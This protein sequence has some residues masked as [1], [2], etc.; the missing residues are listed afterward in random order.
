M[1]NLLT[2][3]RI[4][5]AVL[6]LIFP[7]FS[8]WYYVFY[9]LGG[10]TDAADGA[11]ARI[12]GTATDFGNKFDTAADIVFALAVLLKVIGSLVV[13]R[14]LLVWIGVIVL[15]KAVSLAAGFIR[16]HRFV[17]VHSTL[18]K[19]CGVIVFLSAL[20][21]GGEYVWQAKVLV[22]IFSCVMAS[23]AAVRECAC[24]YKNGLDV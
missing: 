10:A 19:A 21:I 6:I 15:I 16:H 12:S 24:V 13:P 18:N 2:S 14:W 20:F 11:V 1:A 3:I 9:L 22:I 17:A 7:A 8:K 23:A 5:C 4:L